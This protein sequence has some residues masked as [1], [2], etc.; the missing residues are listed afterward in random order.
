MDRAIPYL[1]ISFTVASDAEDD[2]R[3]CA[4]KVKR[5]FERLRRVVVKA[6]EAL[7]SSGPSTQETDTR[8]QIVALLKKG[9]DILEAVMKTVSFSVPLK[10]VLTSQKINRSHIMTYQQLCWTPYS[11]LQ[12]Q[13]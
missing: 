2:G 9:V 6:L 11:L 4:D 8:Q 12:E 1:R 13:L 5:S 7:G 3:R 10:D